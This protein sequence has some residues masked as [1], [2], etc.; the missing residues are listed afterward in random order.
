[1]IKKIVIGVLLLST[2]AFRT[3]AQKTE[4]RLFKI[5]AFVDKLALGYEL[6]FTQVVLLDVT[7]GICGTV[8]VTGDGRFNYYFWK[9]NPFVRGELRFYVN[10]RRRMARGR[11]M[12]NNTGSFVGIQSKLFFGRGGYDASLCNEVHFGQQIS[13]DDKFFFRYHIGLLGVALNLSEKR[14][15]ASYPSLGFSFGYVF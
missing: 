5:E 12:V 3:Y 9:F 14:Y 10:K 15:K 4:T 11:T 13:I 6:P 8:D 7:G 2:W 1:M